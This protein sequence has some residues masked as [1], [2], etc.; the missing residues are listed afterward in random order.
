MEKILLTDLLSDTRFSG[1]ISESEKKRILENKA[2][3]NKSR[4]I[5]K[6]K[7]MYNQVEYDSEIYEGKKRYFLLADKPTNKKFINNKRGNKNDLDRLATKLF[8]EYLLELVNKNNDEPYYTQTKNKWL[9]ES[10][11]LTSEFAKVKFFKSKPREISGENYEKYLYSLSVNEDKKS[12]FNKIVTGMKPIPIKKLFVCLRTDDKWEKSEVSEEEKTNYLSVKEKA[13]KILGEIEGSKYAKN[14]LLINYGI[15]SI[16]IEY[17]IFKDDILEYAPILLNELPKSIKDKTADEFKSIFKNYRDFRMIKAE[18]K[19]PTYEQILQ[20]LQ[21][22]ETSMLNS[23]SRKEIN[24]SNKNRIKAERRYF[25]LI[26]KNDEK[27]G[28]PSKLYEKYYKPIREYEK[29]Q[30][31]DLK[32]KNMIGDIITSKEADYSAYLKVSIEDFY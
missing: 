8:L 11:L 5:K 31:E 21:N 6:V 3:N 15:T 9:T 2:P 7:T 27:N 4:I 32:V 30:V 23:S 1:I 24:I 28:Y 25:D 13:T 19:I 18:L 17:K 22:T 14:Y 10:K 20:N 12:M 16:W 26:V 29:K